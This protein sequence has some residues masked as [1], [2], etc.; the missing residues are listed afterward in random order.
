MTTEKYSLRKH[1]EARRRLREGKSPET[2]QERILVALDC[3]KKERRS[4]SKGI[5]VATTAPVTPK[6][7]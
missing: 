3:G 4:A 7:N 1:L 2:E 6:K 5:K